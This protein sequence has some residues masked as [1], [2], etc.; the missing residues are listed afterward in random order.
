MELCPPELSSMFGTSDHYAS[1]ENNFIFIVE[2]LIYSPTLKNILASGDKR[3]KTMPS[4]KWK[5]NTSKLK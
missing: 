2:G 3:Q 1:R 5:V 4:K